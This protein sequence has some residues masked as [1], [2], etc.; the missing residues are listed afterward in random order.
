MRRHRRKGDGRLARLRGQL[1]ME[2]ARL[3]TQ[4]GV[5]HYYD[6]KRMAA[7]RVLGSQGARRMQFRPRDLPSNGEIRACIDTLSELSEGPQLR[8]LRLFAMRVHAWELMHDLE[9]F[10]PRLIGSVSTGFVRRGSDIDLHVFTNDPD[11]IEAELDELEIGW[12]REQVTIHV[13]AEYREF[14]H[15]HLD[16]TFPVELSVCTPNE[17][18]ER[19][20][21]STDGRPIDRL[22]VA[23]VEGLL[24]RDHA[25]PWVAWL[26]TG[27]MPPLD[28]LF[29]TPGR[30]DALV[31]RDPD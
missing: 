13:G 18:R 31:H 21:S 12:E 16:R 25:A 28:A 11:E 7:Q 15:L 14:L 22:S 2:A 6:A 20:R 1:A 17:L 19:T 5:A 30:F 27:E 9:A 24:L 8:A 26:E 4:E 3:M 23:R 10:S 29:T